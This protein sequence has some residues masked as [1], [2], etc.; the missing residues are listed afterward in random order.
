MNHFSITHSSSRAL[1]KN[2]Q[3]FVDT[4]P[5][6][7]WVAPQ[8]GTKDI[9]IWGVFGFVQPGLQ[10]GRLFMHLPL[11]FSK[12][13][14]IESLK[15]LKSHTSFLFALHIFDQH[16][17]AIFYSCCLCPHQKFLII[18]SMSSHRPFG[19]RKH[20]IV[21]VG[22]ACAMTFIKISL[23]PM[24]NNF[25]FHPISFFPTLAFIH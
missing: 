15:V 1:L 14:K 24:D 20:P 12:H 21:Y 2:L 16:T 13:S 8:I 9:T 10:G 11:L 25:S 22:T 23:P 7:G 4:P 17:Q 3:T 5:C 19:S 18:P 6:I